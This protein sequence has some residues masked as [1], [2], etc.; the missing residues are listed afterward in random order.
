MQTNDVTRGNFGLYA[1]GSK[2]PGPAFMGD[3]RFAA[4]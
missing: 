2:G 3:K 1:S 4:D